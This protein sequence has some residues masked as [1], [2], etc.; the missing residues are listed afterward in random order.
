MIAQTPQLP[1]PSPTPADPSQTYIPSGCRLPPCDT[2]VFTGDYLHSGSEATFITERL[3]N[4]NKLPFQVIRAQVSGLNQTVSAE[5]KKICQFTIRSPT[6]PSLQ[7]NTTAYVLPQIAGNLPSCPLPQHF[8]RDLPELPL[9]DPKFY[10]SAQ[11]DILIG[12]DILPSILLSVAHTYEASLDKL[13]TKFWEVEDLPVKVAKESDLICEDNFLRT[14]SKDET[15]RSQA[16]AQLLRNEQRL[17]RDSTLKSK[18]DSVIQEYLDLNH[19]RE[20]LPTHDSACYYLPHLAVLKPESTTTKLRVVFNASSPSDNRV[21]L[22]HI[23]HAGPVLQS[24]LIIQILKWRYFR[25]VYS[26][27]N[28]PADLGRSA[29]DIVPTYLIPR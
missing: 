11:K 18:Y 24:D 10:E 14:T 4:L 9:A 16:L 20:V 28:V 23:L 12:A 26:I 1:Q 6:R 5:T 19:M 3:F 29:A 7:L 15:G 13:L 22:N 2:E 25:F 8:L 17:K 27:E 21:S